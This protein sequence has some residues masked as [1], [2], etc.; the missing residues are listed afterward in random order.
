MK[1]ITKTSL[2]FLSI[3]IFVF[4]LGIVGFYFLLRN[5]VNQNIDL[6]M[7]LKMEQMARQMIDPQFAQNY[8]QDSDITL[9]TEISPNQNVN[10][11]LK[12]TLIFNKQKNSYQFYRSFSQVVI[13]DKAHYYVQIL[14]PLR[15]FDRL[16]VRITL[17]TTVL[18]IILTV[19]LLVLNWRLTESAWKSFYNTLSKIGGY[20]V[21]S[22]KNIDLEDSDIKEF[23]DLNNVLNSMTDRIQKDYLNI[24]EYTENAAHEFQTPLAVINSKMENLLQDDQLS[25]EQLKSIAEAYEAS[26]RLSRI[27]KTLL[28]LS[29]IDNL[30]FPEKEK[31]DLKEIIRYQ[32]NAVE[33]L[34]DMK[35][36]NID[37]D[38]NSDINLEMNPY[39]ADIMI[40]NLLKNAI[41]H[42]I[43]AGTLKITLMEGCL[44]VSNTGIDTAI[45]SENLF[46]RFRKSS[47]SAESTGLGLAILQKICEVNNFSIKYSF[48]NQLHT[49]LISF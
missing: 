43:D 22:E 12:D 35:N 26:S 19:I 33:E 8:S 30:Q 20:N 47:E 23:D 9:I 28:L 10:I 4:L 11:G 49:F 15:E 46:K 2:N 40:S 21:R 38:F 32:L 29:R 36:I 13:T 24:K 34:I 39:L 17:A 45:D 6:D 27:N 25:E 44:S 3:S 31:V 41:T 5:Q 16:I 14:K 48:D 1:L 42:N 7:Q 18:I 37:E